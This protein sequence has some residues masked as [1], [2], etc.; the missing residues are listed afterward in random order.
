[1]TFLGVLMISGIAPAPEDKFG[2]ETK[3]YAQDASFG[4][5]HLGSFSEHG[6]F[7]AHLDGRELTSID[8]RVGGTLSRW[9]ILGH[10]TIDAL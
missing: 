2:E 1:M 5:T 10:V 9:V 3:V 6:D 8:L 7:V 4:E